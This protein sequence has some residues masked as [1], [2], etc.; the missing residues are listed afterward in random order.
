MRDN[1]KNRLAVGFGI[2]ML[3]MASIVVFN[4]SILRKLEKLYLETF[5]RSVD[6]ELTT[7]AQ[8]IG[9]DMYMIIANAIINRDMAKSEREWAT[10]KITYRAK[11]QKVDQAANTV[12]E[13]TK[14]K[15]AQKAYD[16]II[17][18][19]EKDMLPLIKKGAV[20]P[21]PLSDIDAQIDS[22]IEAIDQALVWVAKSM[23]NDNQKAAREFHELLSDTLK[24]GL[25]LSIF[26]AI[27]AFF[28]AAMTA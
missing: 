1:I 19:Y 10:A 21:G 14:V 3:L 5:K 15:E 20:V 23:S 6:L 7:D 4:Y 22:K 18:I 28:I 16:D 24:S 11:F 13:K 27:V 26:G 17:L 2:T 12:A 9:G 25:L 8:H